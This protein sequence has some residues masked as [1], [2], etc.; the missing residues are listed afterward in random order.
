MGAVA[1][2]GRLA[3]RSLWD[4]SLWSADSRRTG[5]GVPPAIAWTDVA[6]WPIEG[7]AF[8][9]RGAPYDRLPARAK[10]V[11]RDR[12][13]ELSRHTAGMSVRFETDSPELHVRY[14]LTS[15]SLGM[16]HMPPTGV[17]GID[18]YGRDGRTW[19]WIG[20]TMPSKQDVSRRFFADR[21]ADGPRRF[22][23]YLPLYNGI[24][25][26]EL[27]T[28]EGAKITPLPAR[29]KQHK[30]IVC[31]GTSILQG[32]CASRPG[33]AWTSIMGRTLDRE[34][35]NFGFS[36]NGRMELEVGRYLTE[37]PAAAFVVDCLPNMTPKQVAARTQPLV[38][39]L[40]KAQPDVPI[41]LVEDR[42]FTNAW[43][44]PTRQRGHVQRRKA[45]RDAYE[46]LRKDGVAN[47]H[48]LAGADLLGRDGEGAT[49]GSHPND[50]GMM[51]QAAVVTEALRPM[52][53]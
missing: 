17:S 29:G 41:L 35:M 44:D 53:R 45:L 42:T 50:L 18:L 52:L 34:V 8:A 3:P 11:V 37:I 40:R 16:A 46:A 22:Q 27:G 1:L 33:M 6:D 51:R 21:A 7:R 28:A 39:Q 30:P 43:F 13:W 20:V 25:K 4:G 15:A 9:D 2:G 36:G 10:G 26:L 48:Y 47:L 5:D 38:R 12:V 23:L 19:R 32:A 14:R 24:E 49:D 31:Y